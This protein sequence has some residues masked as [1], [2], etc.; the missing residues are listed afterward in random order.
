VMANAGVL[1]RR[2][3]RMFP[4][5]VIA[6]SQV[7]TVVFGRDVDGSGEEQFDEEY[8]HMYSD[9]AGCPSRV[10]RPK[11]LKTSP[12]GYMSTSLAGQ[13]DV[14]SKRG[15]KHFSSAN[16]TG[17]EFASVVFGVQS[18]GS[19]RTAPEGAAGQPSWA[20]QSRGTLSYDRQH[21]KYQAF[22][23]V[24]ARDFLERARLLGPGR[25]GPSDR[26]Y[27]PVPGRCGSSCSGSRA[28]W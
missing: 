26:D 11:G 2:G 15:L 1:K 3:L 22:L 6:Q 20:T 19:A 25:R 14:T 28:V 12:C 21:R 17:N 23:R 5:N 13:D 24:K 10:E 7:D 4:S 18:N 9:A 8:K 27:G 16:T